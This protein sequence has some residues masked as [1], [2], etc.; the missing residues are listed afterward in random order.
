MALVLLNLGTMHAQG[1][2]T[3][4][5]DSDDLKPSYACHEYPGAIHYCSSQCYPNCVETFDSYYTMMLILPNKAECWLSNKE[6]GSFRAFFPTTGIAQAVADTY[7]LF[8]EQCFK[9]D[10]A[11]P[12]KISAGSVYD[13][14]F[15]CDNYL[16][17]NIGGGNIPT[18]EISEDL[19]ARRIV[20]YT[21]KELD[22]CK[23]EFP[24]L[25]PEDDENK[26]IT[27][28]GNGGG[29]TTDPAPEEQSSVYLKA[30]NSMIL[31]FCL[32]FS[33]YV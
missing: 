18:A 9:N 25:Y 14:Y 5:D 3:D 26:S 29:D 21:Q 20:I 17:A 19:W 33:A 10:T 31:F 11:D 15:T 27:D 22:M 6:Y 4:G 13:G 28:G 16:K 2:D 24:L 1:T 30:F 23:A 7:Y 32:A 8:N 12:V